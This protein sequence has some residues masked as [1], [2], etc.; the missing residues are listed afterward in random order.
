MNRVGKVNFILHTLDRLF[1]DPQIPLLHSN[2]FTF[3]VAVMLSAHTTDA[4]VNKITPQL[5]SLADNAHDMSAVP[6]EKIAE[7]IRP[8]GCFN[9]KSIAISAMSNMLVQKFYGEVPNDFTSLESLPGVG[10][11]TASVVMSQAFGVSAFPVDTHIARLAVR[12]EISH[13]TNVLKI[14]DDLK[15]F[16]PIEKWTKLHLQMI[17]FGRKYCPA[18]GHDVSKCPICS[19]LFH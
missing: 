16:F 11:K 15:S 14:E 4:S 12:W 9:R 3:L 17:Y 6:T 18:R 8:C 13:S 2:V 1:P 10:H 7:I 19:E 5:F